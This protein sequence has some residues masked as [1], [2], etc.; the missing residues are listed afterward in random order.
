MQANQSCPAHVFLS[1]HRRVGN[2]QF[3]I[4]FSWLSFC[5]NPRD[6]LQLI[7]SRCNTV[8]T[9]HSGAQRGGS[10]N[11]QSLGQLGTV[12]ENVDVRQM[13]MMRV[14]VTLWVVL[15]VGGFL[16]GFVPEYLKNRE[17]R[18][19]LQDPQKTISS[20]KLQVQLAEL[21][22]TASLVLLELS[23]QNYG[24]ARDYF[25][26]YYE[27]LKEAAEAV[28]DPALKKSLEDLQATREPITSQLAAATAASLT[29][30]QPVFLKTFEATRNVK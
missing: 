10:G 15:L 16:L 28:Q 4:P 14:H 1:G 30:W 26:Q 3:R 18:S 6:S 9:R 11:D 27:K 24:L 22:D 20:L 25:G 17:L 7:C 2:N 19:Q 13:K 5:R 8:Q 21:R 29:A 23:R 12:T